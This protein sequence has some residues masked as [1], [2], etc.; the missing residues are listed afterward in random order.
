MTDSSPLTTCGDQWIQLPQGRIFAR[1]WCASESAQGSPIVLLHDSLGCVE[2]WREF[3]RALSQATGRDVVAYDRLG[4][5][6][7][8]PRTG[9]P[10]LHFIQEEAHHVFPAL[11]ERLGID[12]FVVLGHSVGGGMAV[13]CAAHLPERCEAVVTLA[14]QA[15]LEDRTTH[16]VREAGEQFSAPQQMERLARYHGDKAPWVL[17]AWT[18][19]W[20]HPDFA[21]WSLL[22]VLPRVRCPILAIHGANDEYGSRR[23]PELIGEYAGAGARVEILPEVGH[24]PHREAPDAVLARVTELLRS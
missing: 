8:D 5:G 7:S 14:A 3:P 11:C 24:L 1:R 4:F 16:G 9:R 15:F 6:R 2:L 10:S 19:C 18:G 22:D 21:Q 13:H 12:R 17:D 23:H 20:L